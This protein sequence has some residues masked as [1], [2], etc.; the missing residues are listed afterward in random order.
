MEG[1]EARSL[2]GRMTSVDYAGSNNL[3]PSHSFCGNWQHLS[4]E[5]GKQSGIFRDVT[6]A[7]RGGTV[8]ASSCDHTVQIQ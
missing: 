6:D 3:P 2:Q 5:K 7:P 4:R 8:Q 1:L